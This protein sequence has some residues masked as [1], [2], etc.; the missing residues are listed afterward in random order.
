VNGIAGHASPLDLDAVVMEE[1]AAAH[2]GVALLDRRVDVGGAAHVLE[3]VALG[4][5]D[6]PGADPG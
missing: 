3:P 1:R 5:G 6:H 2:V 4:G